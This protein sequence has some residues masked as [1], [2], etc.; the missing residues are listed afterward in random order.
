MI[1]NTIKTVLALLLF[2]VASGTI[3][4]QVMTLEEAR[5]IYAESMS[6]KAACEA[7]YLKISPI[8]NSENNSLTG[9]KGAITM[10]MAKY[11][12]TPK[13]KM[14]YFKR[15]KQQLESVILK[16]EKNIEL[17]FIRFTIQSNCPAALK[18]D[19]EKASD[20]EFI[21]TNLAS[22]KNTSLK[23]RIKDYMIKSKEITEIEKQKINGI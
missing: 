17:K 23:N 12:K 7:A 11:L 5:K 8:S 20:K 6:N 16:D 9:Y 4:A 15:G 2:I 18:Y 19:K 1:L 13:D 10:A 14:A 21:L 3:Y 22:L